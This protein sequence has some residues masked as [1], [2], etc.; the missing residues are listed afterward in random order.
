MSGPKLR[1]GRDAKKAAKKAAKNL[2]P[3]FPPGSTWM[4]TLGL[5]GSA[6]C[7]ENGDLFEAEAKRRGKPFVIHDKGIVFD[8]NDIPVVVVYCDQQTFAHVLGLFKA[9]EPIAPFACIRSMT[10]GAGWGS[11]GKMPPDKVSEWFDMA[12]DV[13]SGGRS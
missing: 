8:Y 9:T 11:H 1:K 4:L 10:T 7:K 3:E 12:L 13:R 5:Q 2:I 6:N